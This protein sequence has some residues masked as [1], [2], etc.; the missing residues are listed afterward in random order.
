MKVGI[1]TIQKSLNYGAALQSY[2]LWK[3]IDNKGH[4]CEVIDLFRPTLKGYQESRRYKAY[5]E[6]SLKNRIVKKVKALLHIKSKTPKKAVYNKVFKQRM[7]EFRERM[8][9]S[10]P[11]YSVDSLYDNPP[12]YDLYITGSDQVWNPTMGFCMDPYFL[13]FAPK[14]SRKI[15]YAS[16]IG[17]GSLARNVAADYRKWLKEYDAVSVRENTGKELLE[18]IIDRDVKVVL[19]PTF[20]LGRDVWLSLAKNPYQGEDYILLFTLSFDESLLAYARKLRDDSGMKLIYLCRQQPAATD[21]TVVDKAGIEEFIGLIRDAKLMIS[22][23]FHG[24][25]F[26][27]MCGSGNFY[28]YIAQTNKRGS[29]ITDLFETFGLNNHLLKPDL[30][31]TYDAL[32][33]DMVDRGALKDVLDAEVEKSKQFIDKYL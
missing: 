25:V 14:E 19:D 32:Q 24:T 10:A 28:T 3:Y 27:I 26:S 22:N 15:S 29:R 1:I 30:S 16:S 8:K 12:Q 2:A 21:Y 23:S 33:A 6:K 9:M 18:K 31:Q 7:A 13:T 5:A 17:V 20:L 4:D 11:Y